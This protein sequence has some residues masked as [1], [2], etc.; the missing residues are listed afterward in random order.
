MLVDITERKRA[1]EAL[2][3][4]S[5]EQSALY[6][7]TD[8]L[9][10]AG[11]PSDVYDAA[12]CNPRALG[13]ERASILL[14][15]ASDTMKFVAWRGLS[16]G[17]RRAVEGHSP[18]TR[19]AKDPQPICLADLETADLPQ[20]LAATVRAEGIGALAFIPLLAD[21]RL[22]GKFMTYYE[23]PHAFGDAEVDL[24][25]TIARQ[26]GFS[27]ERMR[28]DEARRRAE[29]DLS[30]FFENASVGLHWA[31]PDGIILKAN[32]RELE[33]L[34]YRAEEY[35]GRHVSDFHVDKSVAA[36][37][38]QRLSAGEVLHNYF[39]Q[40]RCKDGSVREVSIASS[41]LWDGNRFLHTR[42][43]T[44]DITDLKRADHAANLLASIVATSEDAIVSK[45]LDGI[46]TSWNGGAQRVFGYTA[47]EMIG[48]SIM[49]LIPDGRHNE[50]PEI[51]GRIRRGDSV[52]HYETV[53]RRKDGTFIDVALTVSPVKDASGKIVGA[54]KIARDVTEQ[55]R[56]QER[57]ELLTR[58]IDHRTKNLFAV[59]HAV[60]ARSFMGKRT[61]KDA[62]EAVLSRLRS[63]AQTHVMLID[64]EWHGADLA[65]VL[66]SELSP[67]CR[68]RARRRA[69]AGAVRQGRAELRAGRARAGHQRGQ[70]WR[71]LHRGGP[72]RYRLVGGQLER[73]GL[74]QVPLAGAGRTAGLAPCAEG[75]RQRR[76][77]AGDGR[78]LQISAESRFRA[79][80]RH[81]RDQRLPRRHR[82][83][84][85]PA[86]AT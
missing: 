17:Y 27:L 22:I 78:I 53:R 71:P 82:R 56:A 66:R 35:I 73:L 34:G 46:V 33:M 48:R 29:E 81:L 45:D 55:K 84:R 3:R 18:W 37:I 32:R 85:P 9:F 20:S 13:C 12:R 83:R 68:P 70:V 25:V 65:E 58:E 77:R 5:E 2:A 21:G 57:Q 44:R 63:L 49:T 41:V 36:D 42:C 14:F 47:E 11:A 38:L 62:E 61:V 43:F 6:R 28:A 40:L 15:D 86:P 31:S 79:L 50:E 10:R 52:E 74:L 23:A 59:V 60:V 1:E 19:D 80:R 16:E 69:E 75:L 24:A 4:R 67:L 30:D 72:R 51:L 39:S 26:L 64:K 8:R 7:F 54:S 76:A